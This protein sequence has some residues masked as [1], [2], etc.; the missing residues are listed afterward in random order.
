MA[1]MSGWMLKTESGKCLKSLLLEHAAFAVRPKMADE[2]VKLLAYLARLT[3]NHVDERGQGLSYHDLRN[4]FRGGK[5]APKAC[6]KALFELGLLEVTA[7]PIQ[8]TIFNEGRNTRYRVADKVMKA[9]QKAVREERSVLGYD[10][11]LCKGTKVE[12]RRRRRL[13]ALKLKDPFCRAHERLC[14]S[15][16]VGWSWTNDADFMRDNPGAVDTALE[17]LGQLSRVDFDPIRR[18]NKSSRLFHPLVNFPSLLR[19]QLFTRELI[20]AGEVDIRACWPT[21]LSA[22]LLE[23]H[24]DADEALKAECAKWQAAFCDDK[25]DPRTTILKE[26]A[27][28]ITPKEMKECLNKY[29]NGAVQAAEKKDR[30]ISARYKVV[31]EWFSCAYPRMHR[32]W[33]AAG[34]DTLGEKIGR[35]FETPLMA[36]GRLY[37]YAGSKGVLI[38]YQ[39][40]GFGVFAKPGGQKA[41]EEVLDGLRRLMRDISIEKFRVPI[42]VR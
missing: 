8:G 4:R 21:F 26:T 5:G 10:G 1:K 29:L 17:I 12:L 11:S 38:C 23:L 33:K 24:K 42:V 35:N 27:L 32:A 6:K 30:T 22:Q 41:L 25:I 36:D 28:A 16:E 31:D 39:Y 15:V 3:R 19:G 37:D 14:C 2:A 9:Y 34:P 18:G 20:Y 40:D 7:K 13:M